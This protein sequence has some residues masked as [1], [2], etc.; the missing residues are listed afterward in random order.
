M[1]YLATT[2]MGG[3]ILGMTP[4]TPVQYI[5]SV[6]LGALSLPVAV[7]SRHLFKVAPENPTSKFESLSRS[8]DL[9]SGDASDPVSRA[10]AIMKDDV[11]RRG[12]TIM[13]DEDEGD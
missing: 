5:I 9:E 10:Y 3:A 13:E 6:V 11:N 12:N 4:L 1:L 7:A 2:K 8:L